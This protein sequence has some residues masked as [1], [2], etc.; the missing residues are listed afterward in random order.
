MPEDK[1]YPY[2]LPCQMPRPN[3]ASAIAQREIDLRP[4]TKQALRLYA[5]GAVKTLAEAARATGIAPGTAYVAHA[6]ATGRREV[7]RVDNNQVEK[8]VNVSQLI[9]SLST[10]AVEK[11]AT[12]M[13]K[14]SSEG[15]QLRAAQDLLDRNPETSKTQKVQVSDLTMQDKDAKLLAAAMV[16]AA[17]LRA[18]HAETSRRDTL[19][20]AE[21]VVIETLNK[22]GSHG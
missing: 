20:I 15:I 14:G 9:A 19:A 17:K 16:E 3:A 22:D 7:A 21:G 18:L 1:H 6:S 10:K 13:E 2:G 12:L 4:A 11:V 5:T 8:A